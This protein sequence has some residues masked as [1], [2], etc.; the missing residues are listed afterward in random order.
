MIARYTVLI[1]TEDELRQPLQLAAAAH[2]Y[3]TDGHIK[4]ESANVQHGRPYDSLVVYAEESPET[5]SKMKHLAIYLAEVANVY[6]II[7]NKDGKNRKSWQLYN[8]D[9]QKGRGA[10]LSALLHKIPFTDI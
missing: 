3:I 10:D 7:V 4:Y 1:P 6:E 5:D 9:Y 8:Q 2:Q